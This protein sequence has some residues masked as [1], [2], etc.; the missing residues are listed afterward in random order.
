MAD[1]IPISLHPLSNELDA[2]IKEE[3]VN[4][5]LYRISRLARI[6]EDLRDDRFN[7]LSAVEKRSLLQNLFDL[8]KQG[9]IKGIIIIAGIIFGET[10]RKNERDDGLPYSIMAAL[11]KGL[12]T[13]R[14]EDI[15]A[16]ILDVFLDEET[17]ILKWLS[18][19]DMVFA[20]L[21]DNPILR[22][23]ALKFLVQ[24]YDPKRILSTLT[25]QMKATGKKIPDSVL[26]AII[27][28]GEQNDSLEKMK[29]V[30]SR[31]MDA[32]CLKDNGI[33]NI[34]E[35]YIK[36]L[37]RYELIKVMSMHDE[38]SLWLETLKQ[39]DPQLSL[40]FKKTG[41]LDSYCSTFEKRIQ[42]IKEI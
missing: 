8:K 29:E 15:K 3:G 5:K 23:R 28:T 10:A 40:H 31:I 33:E 19:E 4:I 38:P 37:N 7:R 20:I 36:G 34:W 22:Y 25:E 35:E 27:G 24:H 1:Q 11:A 18:L 2:I 9:K 17:Q 14:R 42:A 21:S 32:S 39:E 16:I 6:L 41:P 30:L 26:K 13:E 12:H